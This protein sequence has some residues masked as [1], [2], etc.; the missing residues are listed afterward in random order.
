MVALAMRAVTAAAERSASSLSSSSSAQSSS[1]WTSP[2]QHLA[3]LVV[4]VLGQ[5]E[6]GILAEVRDA[7]RVALEHVR[8]GDDA[9]RSGFGERAEVAGEPREATHSLERRLVGIARTLSSKGSV[10]SVWRACLSRTS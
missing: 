8:E 6:R 10:A 9:S 2:T 7:V 3:R 1:L 4:L 5:H